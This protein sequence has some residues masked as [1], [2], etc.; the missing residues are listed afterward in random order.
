[1][2][3][4]DNRNVGCSVYICVTCI[5]IEVDMKT[6]YILIESGE[7]FSEDDTLY[8]VMV[9]NSAQDMRDFKKM[10]DYSL[11]HNCYLQV[12][13]QKEKD[14]ITKLAYSVNKF[15]GQ[16]KW[17]TCDVHDIARHIRKFKKLPEKTFVNQ[18]EMI[19]RRMLSYM[20]LNP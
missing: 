10:V 17:L 14:F 15:P 2:F 19:F 4:L 16:L 18:H 5:F 13:S 3:L 7:L 9:G 1:M 20:D 11:E 8:R 12:W 6:K